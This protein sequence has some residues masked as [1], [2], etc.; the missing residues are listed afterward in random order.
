MTDLSGTYDGVWLLTTRPLGYMS[1]GGQEVRTGVITEYGAVRNT[2]TLCISRIDAD[3]DAL[4]QMAADVQNV[5]IKS[6]SVAPYRAGVAVTLELTEYAQSYTM[7]AHHVYSPEH[8][9][10]GQPEATYIEVR[11]SQ[12][13][14]SFAD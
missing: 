2:L 6:V 12:N 13:P 1:A 9:P 11:F 4:A 14:G 10:D 5:F 3:M 8:E 7:T